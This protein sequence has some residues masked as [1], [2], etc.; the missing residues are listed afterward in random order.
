M[1][2]MT[3]IDSV[4]QEVDAIE[5]NT[6][7]HSEKVRWLS[8]LDG[9]LYELYMKGRVGAPAAWSPYTPETPDDTPLLVQHPWDDIYIHWLRAQIALF[10]GENDLY[11]D[12]MA[13]V[14]Q[15]EGF[16]ASAYAAAHPR[17]GGDRFRF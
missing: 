15:S 2:D 4:I 14:G 13:L 7:D 6:M 8:R 5:H 9:R 17:A 11:S 16:F 3:T 10:C 12:C 1:T